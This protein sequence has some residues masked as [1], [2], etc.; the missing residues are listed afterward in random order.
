MQE[1]SPDKR[2]SWPQE[3]QDLDAAIRAAAPG[4]RIED[5]I[6]PEHYVLPPLDLAQFTEEERSWIE[7]VVEVAARFIN[8]PLIIDTIGYH[9]DRI[10]LRSKLPPELERLYLANKLGSNSFAPLYSSLNY[11]LSLS[12]MN[13]KIKMPV[14]KAM[15]S[16]YELLKPTK[17]EKYKVSKKTKK[18]IYEKMSLEK[19]QQFLLELEASCRKLIETLARKSRPPL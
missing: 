8:L 1:N 19:K 13:E 16:V 2:L 15:D 6:V 14:V 4:E 7:Y 11:L 3:Y 18:S 12:T 10:E 5:V 17:H 9:P